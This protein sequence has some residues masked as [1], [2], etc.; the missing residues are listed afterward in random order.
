[1]RLIFRFEQESALHSYSPVPASFKESSDQSKGPLIGGGPRH[2]QNFP[3]LL[4]HRKHIISQWIIQLYV[5]DVVVS[6]EG[7]LGHFQPLRE[8]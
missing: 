6:E 1:M 8:V 2:S 4:R 3:V 5:F 7:A